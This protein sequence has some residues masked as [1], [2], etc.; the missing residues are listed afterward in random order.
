MIYNLLLLAY[1][2][3]VPYTSTSPRMSINEASFGFFISLTNW[4]TVSDGQGSRLV[5][6][7]S[8]GVPMTLHVLIC[9]LFRTSMVML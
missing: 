6:L 2:P 4:P 1:I 7:A 5:S 9:L 3:F 8:S